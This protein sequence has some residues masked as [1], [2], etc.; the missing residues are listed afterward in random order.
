M[1]QFSPA[2][3]IEFSVACFS[4][5]LQLLHQHHIDH[6]LPPKIRLIN[7]VKLGIKEPIH[8]LEVSQLR[9][10]LSFRACDT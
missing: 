7:H 3:T 2:Y 8:R 9:K 6:R 4:V 10:T 5:A 1:Y